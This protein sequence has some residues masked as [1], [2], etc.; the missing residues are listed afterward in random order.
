MAKPASRAR[1]A[2]PSLA[3]A[4]LNLAAGAQAEEVQLKAA[5]HAAALLLRAVVEL[6]AVGVEAR[7]A[8][9][10]VPERAL[11]LVLGLSSQVRVRDAGRRGMPMVRLTEA[12]P[13][14]VRGLEVE[15][16]VVVPKVD[17]QVLPLS[18][19]LVEHSR[20]ISEVKWS[21]GGRWGKCIALHGMGSGFVCIIFAFSFV[22]WDG[23][24]G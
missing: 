17:R 16:V 21:E 24:G 15:G 2:F 22:R 10:T 4:S 20:M 11:T 8:R 14:G 3:A 23:D 18:S 7:R 1:P 6:R 19:T 5:S 12:E 9:T 13:G